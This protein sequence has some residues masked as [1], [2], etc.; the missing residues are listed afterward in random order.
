MSQLDQILGQGIET[1]WQDSD[2]QAWAQM[3]GGGNLG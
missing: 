3:C 1:F 2:S